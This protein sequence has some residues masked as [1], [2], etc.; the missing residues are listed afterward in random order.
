MDDVNIF[1]TANRVLDTIRNTAT[2]DGVECIQDIPQDPGQAGK[3]QVQHLAAALHGYTV[4][5]SPESGDKVVR[6]YPLSAQA[7]AG[8]IK[9]VRGLWNEEYLDEI[10]YFP[11][12]RKDRVDATV[13]A[14]NRALTEIKISGTVVGGPR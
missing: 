13:R 2:Q 7:E 5:S 8:N 9:L 11:N 4:R 6:A 10:S 12:G 14:Y 1:G 3:A